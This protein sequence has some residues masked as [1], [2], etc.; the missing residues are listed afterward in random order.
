MIL[1]IVLIIILTIPTIVFHFTFRD[2][3]IDGETFN[4]GTKSILIAIFPI[5][6]LLFG[7]YLKNIAKDLCLENIEK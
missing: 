2:I 1:L 6:L 5:L 7:I 3:I 4:L